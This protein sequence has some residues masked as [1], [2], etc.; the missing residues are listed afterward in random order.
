MIETVIA[1]CMFMHG[2]LKEH[3]HQAT[4]HDCLMKKRVAERN[5]SDTIRYSCGEVKGIIEINNDGSKSIK[6][7]ISK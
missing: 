2:E 1:L 4:I 7:I 3:K 6:K 5:S